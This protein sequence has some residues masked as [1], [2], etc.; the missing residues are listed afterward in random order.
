MISLKH[1]LTKYTNNVHFLQSNSSKVFFLQY[2]KNTVLK[3]CQDFTFFGCFVVFSTT[4][5]F[6]EMV[7]EGIAP[8]FIFFVGLLW[9]F[10]VEVK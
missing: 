7:L 6:F 10:I 1:S 2:K 5:P 8:S 4:Y 9:N 3:N